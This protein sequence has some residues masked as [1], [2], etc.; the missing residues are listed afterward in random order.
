MKGKPIFF[1]ATI[2]AGALLW[3]I[4]ADR[5]GIHS[6]ASSNESSPSPG[7]VSG[8]SPAGIGIPLP[9]REM[10]LRAT[11][12]GVYPIQLHPGV[13]FDETGPVKL[14]DEVSVDGNAGSAAVSGGHRT[15]GR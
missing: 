11:G 5:P 15:T 8:G 6:W 12:I 2:L 9:D 7:S 3:Q 4:S 1:I 14:W 13:I 10:R